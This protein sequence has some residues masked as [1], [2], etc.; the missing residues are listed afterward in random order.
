LLRVLAGLYEPQHGGYDVDGS[1]AIRVRSLA[2]ISRLIPQETEIF[3]ATLRDNLTFGVPHGDDEIERVAWLSALDAVADSLPQKWNMPLAERGV[4]LSGGQRQRL[5]LARGLLAGAN[6]SLLLLDE[7][8]SALDQATEAIVF[9]RLR[10]G[11]ADTCLI[12]SIHRLSALVYFDRVIVMADGRVVDAGTVAEILER[13]PAFREVV[14]SAAHGAV[15][16]LP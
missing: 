8:T 15:P 1:A 4:N 7:P 9:E 16:A 13:Q 3:E 2:S 10:S 12:A 6:S 11:L 14:Y 5:S